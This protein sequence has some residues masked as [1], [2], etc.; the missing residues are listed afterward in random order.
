MKTI[1]LTQGQV[2][3]VDDEDYEAL[4]QHSWCVLRHKRAWYAKRG[5]RSNGK[6]RTIYM[7]QDILGVFD[8]E[9]DHKDN[10]GLNN[11]RSNI[12]VCTSSQNKQN[13]RRQ[14]ITSSRFKGVYWAKRNCKW[15]ARIRTDGV[16]RHLGT[17]SNEVEAAQA[18]AKAAKF[19][20]GEYAKT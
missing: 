2:A 15:V 20:F 11:C 7:H 9:I 3:T 14:L 10:N 12:R 8:Q 18:Y 5:S 6:Q 16:Q 4:M 13:R 1:P 17:F 19:Y